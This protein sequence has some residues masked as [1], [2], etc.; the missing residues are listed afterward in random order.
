[1]LVHIFSYSLETAY[2]GHS[3]QCD[4]SLQ[5]RLICAAFA[6]FTLK[7]NDILIIKSEKR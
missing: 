2:L 3:S 4:F 5:H 1:M 6:D 7:S